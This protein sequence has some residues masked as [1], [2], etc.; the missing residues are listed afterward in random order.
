MQQVQEITAS[1][2]PSQK[3]YLEDNWKVIASRP[4]TAGNAEMSKTPFAPFYSLSDV[5]VCCVNFV[6]SKY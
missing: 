5:S 6:V 3:L 2:I 4:L 1:S